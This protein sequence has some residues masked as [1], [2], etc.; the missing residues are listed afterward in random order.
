MN[1]SI[2]IWASVG[3]ASLTAGV[4]ALTFRKLKKWVK[5]CKRRKPGVYGVR[6]DK[7]ANRLRREWAYVG[8]SVN[9]FLRQKDHLGQGRFGN[10]PKPWTTLNPTFHTLVKLPWWLGWKWIL[11]PLETVLI[12]TLWPRYN[13]AKNRWNPRRVSRH[14]QHAQ[15]LSRAQGGIAYRARVWSAH[16]GRRLIQISGVALIIIGIYGWVTR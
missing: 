16:L 10:K 5:K 14:A 12:L 8:E 1:H 11:P 15:A 13:E 9:L 2:I 7:H 6:C 4:L 3:G